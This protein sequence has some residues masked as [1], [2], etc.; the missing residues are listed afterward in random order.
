[1]LAILGGL[2][3][4]VAFAASTLASTRSSRLIGATSTVAWVM[5][6]GLPVATVPALLDV[7]GLTP[8]AYPWLL[9]SAIGN[10]LGL[11]GEYAALRVGRVGVVAPLVATEGAI[12]AII[13]VVAGAPLV[14]G[15]LPVLALV[16][17][18]SALTAA[19]VEPR[20]VA[21]PGSPPRRPFLSVALAGAAAIAFGV[22]LYATGRVSQSLALGWVALSPR[23][24][25]VLLVAVPLISARRL[26]INRSAAPLVV[27][28]GLAEVA[29]F[30]CV[31]FGARSDLAITSVLAAQFAALAVIGA[32]FLFREHLRPVQRVGVLAIAVGTGLLALLRL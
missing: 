15:L 1:M 9:L 21:E 25:G 31:G 4:A 12:A 3:A 8:V 23:V 22:S 6:V 10:V 11:A 2:G 26:R 19:S 5:L 18:G 17:I 20:E 14:A 28:A 32:V 27:I 29:G 13:S 16:V 30:Y 24:A 7:R